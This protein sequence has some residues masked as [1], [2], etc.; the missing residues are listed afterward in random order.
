MKKNSPKKNTRYYIKSVNLNNYKAFQNPTK[1]EFAQKINLIF[2][3]NSS[4]KSSIFQSIRLFR[5][6]IDKGNLVPLNWKSPEK[7]RDK[8]GI[9]F[10]GDYKEIISNGDLKKNLSIGIQIEREL[11]LMKNNEPN[12]Y[13]KMRAYQNLSL[14]N[15][16]WMRSDFLAFAYKHKKRFYKGKNLVNENTILDSMSFGSSGNLT[17]INFPKHVFFSEDSR[18]AKILSRREKT[19]NQ[20][21]LG[22]RFD[23]ERQITIDDDIYKQF[24]FKVKVL[25]ISSTELENIGSNFST[26]RKTITQYLEDFLKKLQNKK[27]IDEIKEVSSKDQS[28]FLARW[29]AQESFEEKIRK[30]YEN[31]KIVNKIEGINKIKEESFN[32]YYQD[33]IDEDMTIDQIK[34][35]LK[36]IIKFFKEK[37]SSNP[38]EFGKFFIKDIAKKFEQMVYYKGV[39]VPDPNKFKK[40]NYQ[41]TNENCLKY[42]INFIGYPFFLFKKYE[43]VQR[44]RFFSLLENYD[45]G[46]QA[47]LNQL[48][49]TLHPDGVKV[50]PGLRHLP[51]R[52]FLKG[53]QTNYVGP[54]A[55]NLAKIL[56]TPSR[57]NKVNSWFRLLDIPYEIGVQKSGNYY[58]IIWTPKNSKLKINQLNVGLGYPISLPFIVQAII[59]EDSIIVVEEPE[60]H[61]HPK[62]EADLADLICESAVERRNQFIIETHSE[63]LL[64]RIMKKIRKGELSNNDVSVNYIKPDKNIKGSKVFPIKINKY[65]QYKTP[66]KDDLFAERMREFS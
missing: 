57:R 51:R 36:K 47:P 5:Q 16:K 46:R 12:E 31:K 41:Q 10:E 13:Q 26:Q 11:P 61:L 3:R 27:F 8:G 29:T 45:R 66:W 4:G 24:Y 7:F 17:H 39:F 14:K 55:E 1:I 35:N 54:Q 49:N 62:L 23:D 50:I 18:E 65:G 63:D 44:G 37:N 32:Y 19:V 21:A 64:L 48:L 53:I 60:I 28:S 40:L 2:G 30:I 52:Y 22:M 42:L 6:S 38:K 43:N 59:A 25:S 56:A 58:E 15:N 34:K 20:L 33:L 9:N